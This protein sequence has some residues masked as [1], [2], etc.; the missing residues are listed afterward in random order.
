MEE[1]I[2]CSDRNYALN[3]HSSLA[4]LP[5]RVSSKGIFQSSILCTTSSLR[6]MTMPSP[7]RTQSRSSTGPRPV[8]GA[9]TSDQRHSS[10][11][12]HASENSGMGSSPTQPHFDSL[13]L[14]WTKKSFELVPDTDCDFP[15]HHGLSRPIHINSSTW[16][17]P[18]KSWP[19][20]TA[21]LR[22]LI[23]HRFVSSILTDMRRVR[24]DTYPNR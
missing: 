12:S 24:S 22:P 4:S 13:Q 15:P 7:T 11:A 10:P 17:N 16:L 21:Q 9:C 5:K 2:P 19:R 20:P 14:S 3:R 18:R 6:S 1:R 23:P 8:S